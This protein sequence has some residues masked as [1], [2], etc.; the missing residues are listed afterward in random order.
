MSDKNQL[1]SK[2]EKL[3]SNMLEIQAIINILELK[4]ITTK[5]EIMDEQIRKMSKEN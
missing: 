4:G 3:I 5:D 1:V 2:D